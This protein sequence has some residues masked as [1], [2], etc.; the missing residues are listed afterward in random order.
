[1]GQNFLPWV[2][3]RFTWYLLLGNGPI[4]YLKRA[5][6]LLLGSRQKTL[7]PLFYFLCV[8]ILVNAQGLPAALSCTRRG[9]KLSAKE[10]H[11][12][13]ERVDGSTCAA[14]FICHCCCVYLKS[15]SES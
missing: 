3:R 8:P 14:S 13:I 12:C 4:W 2:F 7:N 10:D 6:M 11:V 5:T 1:M 9:F 15:R